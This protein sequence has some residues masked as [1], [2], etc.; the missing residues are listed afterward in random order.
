MSPRIDRLLN[1]R[2]RCRS[3]LRVMEREAETEDYADIF[4]QTRRLQAELRL[5]NAELDDEGMAA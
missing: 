1:D 3:E 5:I 4:T 2:D